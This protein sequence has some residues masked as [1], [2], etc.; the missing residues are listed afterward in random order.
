VRR[1]CDVFY[2]TEVVHGYGYGQDED[3]GQLGAWY[4]LA[5]IGLFDVQGGTAMHPTMQLAAPLFD[6]VRIRLNRQYCAGESFEIQAAGSPVG[7]RYIQLARLNGK[8]LDRCWIP[9][10][11]ITRG[12]KLELSLGNDPK[13]SWGVGVPP[14]S[15]SSQG[16]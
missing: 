16:R 12:G 6:R 11:E 15:G 13:M 2:G 7:E 8:A 3:Q 5:S 14:P 1:I 9:W 4:V 10:E